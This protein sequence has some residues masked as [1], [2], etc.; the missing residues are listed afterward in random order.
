MVIDPPLT[1][2]R[3]YIHG[4]D[5]F[6][7]LLALTGARQDMVL[8]LRAASDCAIAVIDGAT[9]PD[10]LACGDFRHRRAGQI[11][12]LLLRRLPDRPIAR[13]SALDDATLAAGATFA[14]DGARLPAGGDASFVM[15][16]TALCLALLERDRPD[17]YWTLAEIAC[18]RPPPADAA[19]AITVASHVG[20][21]YRKA[22]LAADREPIGHLVLAQGSPRR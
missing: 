16:A 20:G 11:R 19:V 9:A 5:I 8:A 7:A 14:R 12:R 17:D 2:E 15:R 4:A 3:S 1:G 18:R 22:T 6:D 10:S 21:R 13:R